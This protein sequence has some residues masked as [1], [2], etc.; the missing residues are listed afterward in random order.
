MGIRVWRIKNKRKRKKK[1][2]KRNVWSV[3]MQGK[4]RKRIKNHNKMFPQYFHNISQEI[5]SDR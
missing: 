1:K 2:R 4:K 5:L 3:W